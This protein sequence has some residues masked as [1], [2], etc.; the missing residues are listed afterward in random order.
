MIF[1]AINKNRRNLYSKEPVNYQD[2]MHVVSEICIQGLVLEVLTIRDSEF[3]IIM[4][5]SPKSV[6][7]RS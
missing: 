1:N 3:R 7:Q 5:N 6:G 2:K 4:T